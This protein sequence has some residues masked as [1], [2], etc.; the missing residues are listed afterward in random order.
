MVLFSNPRSSYLHCPLFSQHWNYWKPVKSKKSVTTWSRLLSTLSNFGQFLVP[1]LHFLSSFCRIFPAELLRWAR[2][3]R[4]LERRGKKLEVGSINF[5][6]IS[7]QNTLDYGWSEGEKRR[8]YQV[9]TG[10][11]GKI[12][13]WKRYH[14]THF[15]VIHYLLSDW[16]D[17]WR[18]ARDG[19]WR[20]GA[21]SGQGLIDIRCQWLVRSSVSWCQQIMETRGYKDRTH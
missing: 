3:H 19:R 20:L 12:N 4:Q 7:S 6:L 2:Q 8:G 16:G 13:N 18:D 9:E 17:K 15:P 1:T 5:L 11:N 10:K 14:D 21:V